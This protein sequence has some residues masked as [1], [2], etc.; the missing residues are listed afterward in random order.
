MVVGGCDTCGLILDPIGF[1]PKQRGPVSERHDGRGSL[2]LR[3]HG[4]ICFDE[5]PDGMGYASVVFG[6]V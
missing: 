4:S 2:C 5:L 1:P 6:C 3:G